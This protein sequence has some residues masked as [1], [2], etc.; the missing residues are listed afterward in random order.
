MIEE[1]CARL[2]P[3][4]SLKKKSHFF[5]KHGNF[6]YTFFVGFGLFNCITYA[7]KV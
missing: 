7:N 6:I 5:I 3:D 1:F 4:W 2:E